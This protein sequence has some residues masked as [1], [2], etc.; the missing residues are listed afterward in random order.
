MAMNF[1]LIG[2]MTSQTPPIIKFSASFLTEYA[3][4]SS[5]IPCRP[6]K[7]CNRIEINFG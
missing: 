2:R 5:K 6:D 7:L 4:E 3:L 1:D